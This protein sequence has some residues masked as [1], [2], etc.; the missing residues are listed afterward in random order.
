MNQCG[1][2][3]ATVAVQVYL[4]KPDLQRTV[5]AAA[6]TDGESEEYDQ[7][8]SDSESDDTEGIDSDDDDDYEAGSDSTETAIAA[9]A[10]KSAETLAE[11][12]SVESLVAADDSLIERSSTATSTDN[13]CAVLMQ[14][15]GTGSGRAISKAD[16]PRDSSSI[17]PGAE[18]VNDEASLSEGTSTDALPEDATRLDATAGE[19]DDDDDDVDVDLDELSAL[20][21][22]VDDCDSTVCTLVVQK[23]QHQQELLV[24]GGITRQQLTHEVDSIVASLNA[25]QDDG[26]AT[27]S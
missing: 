16:A 13:G 22:W 25:A 14:A 3:S 10:Q 23:G 20:F 18:V 1:I 12:P 26:L 11:D 7:S 21:G 9:T 15:V 24:S 19:E 2:Q 6:P 8:D 5:S 17:M 27:S 4:A